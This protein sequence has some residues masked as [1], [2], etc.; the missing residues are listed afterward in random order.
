MLVLKLLVNVRD[1]PLSSQFEPLKMLPQ[2]QNIHKT[3]M[4]SGYVN[5]KVFHVWFHSDCL[6]Q[7]Y[8]NKILTCKV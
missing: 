2:I 8:N 7:Y 4:S 6:S 1:T 3:K 5:F